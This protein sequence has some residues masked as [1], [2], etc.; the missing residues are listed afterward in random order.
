MT[1]HELRDYVYENMYGVIDWEVEDLIDSQDDI[2]PVY[3]ARLH[4][5]WSDA[6][7][8]WWDVPEM[9]IPRC[10]PVFD[11]GHDYS[12]CTDKDCECFG[13]N[14]PNDGAAFE[15]PALSLI[16]GCILLLYIMRAYSLE[17]V[18]YGGNA[19]EDY[20]YITSCTM[21]RLVCDLHEMT[22]ALR[23]EFTNNLSAGD[24]ALSML[25]SVFAWLKTSED[26]VCVFRDGGYER[27]DPEKLL[28]HVVDRCANN[29][30]SFM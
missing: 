3:L 13:S 18:E 24:D 25:Q 1:W 30:E 17:F 23:A 10:W 14:G 21:S 9:R 6:A 4:A 2:V 27:I 12:P 22:T 20:E 29:G 26:A 8:S 28:K 16:K 7:K 11:D 15:S 19:E 5:F